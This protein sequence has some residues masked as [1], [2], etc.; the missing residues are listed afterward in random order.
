M[1]FS[2]RPATKADIPILAEI[3]RKAF[4]D[5]AVRFGLTEENCPKHPSNCKAEWIEEALAKGVRYFLLDSEGLPCGCVALEQA[6]PEVCYL[7]R[8]AVLPER[9]RQGLGR[10]L[11][12][13]ALNE[14]G[15]LGATQ[16][17]IG[18]I[19]EQTELKEWY[20]KI[21]FSEQRKARF[22]HLPFEVLF[23]S[24][25]ITKAITDES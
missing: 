6:G 9:R 16:V 10:A 22:P 7:E 17:D 13:H 3:I 4:Y 1:P 14:A 25:T 23:M 18:I 20:K 8:L 19:A 2:I 24:I 15:K 5:V 12:G 11:V 21:G